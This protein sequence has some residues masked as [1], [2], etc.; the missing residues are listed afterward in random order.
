MSDEQREQSSLFGNDAPLIESRE[1]LADINREMTERAALYPE[2]KDRPLMFGEGET[3]IKLALVGESPSPPD[4]NSGHLFT[5][6]SG[7]L[8]DRILAAINLTRESLYIT[9]A[10]KMVCSGDEITPSVLSFFTPY[11][12]RELAVVRP[13]IIIASGNTPT[14]ALLNSKKGITQMRGEFHNY[15]G[16]QLMPMFNPAYLLR[17]PTKKREVW[18]DMKKVRDLYNSLKD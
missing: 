6:P 10:I 13:R 4:I 7:D 1:T 15:N 18:E 12:H 9:N 17:D 14:K 11:L 2:I 8:L 3:N 16:A 5:G